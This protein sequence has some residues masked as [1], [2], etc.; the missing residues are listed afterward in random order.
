MIAIKMAIRTTSVQQQSALAFVLVVMPTAEQRAM[1]TKMKVKGRWCWE[2][3][4]VKAPT[5]THPRKVGTTPQL[6]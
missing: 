3:I 4:V 5:P 1:M 2:L 6:A